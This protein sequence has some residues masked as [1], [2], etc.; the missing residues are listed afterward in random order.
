MMAWREPKKKSQS[1]I[2]RTGDVPESW[3]YDERLTRMAN[4]A[5]YFCRTRINADARVSVYVR[6]GKEGNYG[7]CFWN[8]GVIVVR[9]R[10]GDHTINHTL[11]HEVAHMAFHSHGK[12]HKEL[13]DKIYT[14]WKDTNALS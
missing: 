2:M 14:Y 10:E 11:A 9:N 1:F 7:R 4:D 5:L 6:P 3:E 8:S 13:T 12:R